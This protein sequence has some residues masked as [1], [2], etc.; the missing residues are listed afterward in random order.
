ML[1]NL[2]LTPLVKLQDTII[3]N[4]GVE[5]YIKK[6]YLTDNAIS[7]N[8]WY[9][10]KYNL[11]AAKEQHKHTL[12]TFGGAYSNHI[13]ATAAAGYRFG[14]KTIGIIR[15]ELP[16]QLNATLQQ[17]IAN[18]MDLHFIDRAAYRDKDNESFIATL[19]KQFGDFYLIPEGGANELGIKGCTEIIDELELDFDHICCA[20]GTGS[21]LAGL[22]RGLKPEQRATGFA[23]LN[24]AG[25]LT[26]TVKRVLHKPGAGITA[27]GN[28]TINMD[29]HFGGYAK[30]KPHL[31]QF[32]QQFE[33]KHHIPLDYVYTGKMMCG[34]YDLLAKNYFK[35]GEKIIALHTG[36]LQG[37]QY[38]PREVTF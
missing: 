14:F 36:G 38:Y 20:C 8:K 34:L 12:L 2:P 26:D 17:A 9:K 30:T 21:T 10:L 29:Y 1:S 22:L 5:V 4:H 3:D 27:I 13:A 6:L 25:F 35:T 7:G 16:R 31:H 37:N 28:W 24:G 33:A 15:G 19:K 11:A 18:G 32:M 23:V